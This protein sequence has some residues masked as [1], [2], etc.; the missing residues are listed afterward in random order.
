ME[1]NFTGSSRPQR[2]IN[3][4]GA[5]GP[6]ASQLAAQARMLRAERQ[7][8]KQR[9]AAAT[10]IQAAFR[11]H[12][13]AARVRRQCAAELE[14]GAWT[15]PSNADWERRTRLLLF[16]YRATAY[17]SRHA[18]HVAT[19]AQ[20][21]IDAALER[22]SA[23][24]ALIVRN[25]LQ[26]LVRFPTQLGRLGATYVDALLRLLPA[27]QPTAPQQTLLT[28][29]LRWG[30]HAALSAYVATLP[31]ERTNEAGACVELSLRPFAVFP[32]PTDTLAETV[33]DAAAPP[34]ASALRGFVAS[35]L[36]TAQL[37]PRLPLPSVTAL[38]AQLPFEETTEHLRTLG[39]YFDIA[40]RDDALHDNPIHS[41][42]LLSNYVALG[43]KRVARMNAQQLRA[44]LEVLTLLQNTL[45]PKVFAACT[46]TEPTHAPL[47][48]AAMEIDEPSASTSAAPAPERLDASTRRN[49]RALVSDTHLHAL[50][51]QSTRYA[52]QTRAAICAF[53]VATLQVWPSSAS[54]GVLTTVLYGYD[55]VG[56]STHAAHL[57]AV[58]AMVR[59]LWRGYVR[60]SSLARQLNGASS[61]ARL[62]ETRQALTD[63]ARADEWP[64][65]L[66]LS[67]LYGRALLTM[68]DDEFYPADRL[69]TA[70]KNPL[71][72]DELVTLSGMLRNLAFA[73][74]WQQDLVNDAAPPAL[75]PGTVVPLGAL[76]ETVT[77]LLQQLHTR[78]ARRPFTPDG[79][80]HM[81]SQQDL[82][83]FIQSVI[84]EERELFAESQGEASPGA[85]ARHPMLSSRTLAFIGP[86]LNVL[87]HIPFV[88][89]FE[90]RVEIF[91]QFVRSDA[92]RLHI[93]RDLFSRTNR[94]RATV[95]RERIAEDGMAQLNA[96]GPR[97]KEPVEIVFIDQ[98]GQPEAGI[99][100]G[101]VFK[102]FLTSLVRQV[103]D[104]DRGLWRA[105]E[106]QELYPNPHS[107]SRQPEQLEWYT[108]LGRILGKAL[109]EGILV[110]VKLA[111]F[112]LGKWLGH[113]SYL[114][115]LASLQSLDADLYRGLIQLKNYPGD[116]ENDLALNFTVADEEFGVT[117]TTELVP[118]GA[119]IPV[120]KENR[121]AYI[122]H[123][124]RYRLSKQ[125]EPQ[126]RAFF[127]GLSELIDPRWLRVLSRDELRVLVSGTEAPID[128][129][130]LRA[131]TVY[132][133]YHEK[134]LAVTYFWEALETLDPASRKAFLRFVTSSPNP[135]LLG[136]GELH[137]QFA[138]R[139]AG[140]DVTRL[141]TAST[142]VNLLKLPAYTSREQC[143]EKLRY[144][145][146]SEAG[147]DL[148]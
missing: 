113:Q 99:D 55:S 29:A 84:V 19:W 87:H 120:T 26:M 36:T 27:D 79:H 43:S 123:V 91:R 138:I 56:R 21:D 92:E 106:R 14:R 13:D 32:G 118:G 41:P 12:S 22:H 62:V 135:P 107:Y 68:G 6:S 119:E 2:H 20:G 136:F 3:L 24:V 90:V 49:L 117:H 108:F 58:G 114:D 146:H 38:A 116:V 59:E 42:Y 133:G 40:T 65:L 66:V 95:R 102:E 112:F 111:N 5:A 33:S 122:Y 82:A 47:D 8:Q 71:T 75:V 73:L 7:V 93:S 11:A 44:Y 139:H 147:F 88:I 96:L 130:D 63:P 25:M 64:V 31:L 30:L 15:A 70:G 1:Y 37:L 145:I 74:Y 115:D 137:P 81:L 39:R 101:G 57:P 125:I 85:R 109:Y 97:L 80:W 54:E 134:D 148:S 126:C 18:E 34:R 60:G 142:C 104:T 77:R 124:S 89:P 129:T 4:G 121:L 51:A 110:D 143:L 61:T 94:H 45:P 35:L 76:R 10:R 17:D 67:Q 100:G 98:F 105:N 69:Q 9:N 86:R 28:R 23:L 48:S 128:L 127:Q 16:S 141:P 83:S 103:F 144:A 46:D 50:L 140:D 72:L 53:L 52:A 78:D 132:G 131:H